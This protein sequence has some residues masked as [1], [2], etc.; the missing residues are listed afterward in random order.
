MSCEFILLTPHSI[1]IQVAGVNL[2]LEKVASISGGAGSVGN[3]LIEVMDF[4]E[5]EMGA[6]VN[7][8]V[9]ILGSVSLVTSMTAIVSFFNMEVAARTTQ[10]VKFWLK[11]GGRRLMRVAF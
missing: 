5:A 6:F 7:E 4:L 10:L 8:M 2:H 9:L 3:D 11:S 1:K